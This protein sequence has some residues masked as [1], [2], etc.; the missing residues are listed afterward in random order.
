M[1]LHQLTNADVEYH[2]QQIRTTYASAQR[3]I[4]INGLREIVGNTFIQMGSYIHGK[5]K[6]ACQD[7]AQTRDLIRQSQ[8][9]WRRPRAQ[10]PTPFVH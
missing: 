3:L 1:F 4:S 5:A 10:L 6:E 9:E 2:H 8:R 7:A